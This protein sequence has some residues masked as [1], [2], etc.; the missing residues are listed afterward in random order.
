MTLTDLRGGPDRW[1]VRTTALPLR[2]GD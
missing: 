1:T 2:E